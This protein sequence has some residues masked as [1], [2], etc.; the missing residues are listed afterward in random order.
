MQAHT[1]ISHLRQIFLKKLIFAK[2]FQFLYDKGFFTILKIIF[3]P[4]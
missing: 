2:A 1:S 4:G 3:S